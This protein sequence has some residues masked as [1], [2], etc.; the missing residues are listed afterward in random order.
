MP[1]YVYR[2]EAGHECDFVHSMLDAPR[3]FCPECGRQMWKRPIAATVKWS[4]FI[5]Q[6]PAIREHLAT[7]SQ[8]REHY[9]EHHHD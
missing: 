7:V 2:C 8:Q 5:E 9:L 6:S 3:V 4:S 1:V